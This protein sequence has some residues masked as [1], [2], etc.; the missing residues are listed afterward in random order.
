MSNEHSKKTVT[1]TTTNE[2]ATSAN[3]NA[4][5]QRKPSFNHVMVDDDIVDLRELVKFLRRVNGDFD[6]A[7]IHTE[8][9][10]DSM[11]GLDPNTIA[12]FSRFADSLDNITDPDHVRRL[13]ESVT[14]EPISVRINASI[15][16]EV[17]ICTAV[18][19][20]IWFYQYDDF[21][22]RGI[23][24]GSSLYLV[25]CLIETPSFIGYVR[26]IF[27]KYVSPNVETEGPK[28]NL[29]AV[30][31][32]VAASSAFMQVCD[33]KSYD[34]FKTVQSLVTRFNTVIKDHNESVFQFESFTTFITQ[35][36]L[37][38]QDLCGVDWFEGIV[39][40]YDDLEQVRQGLKEI[41]DSLAKPFDQI[42]VR[43]Q[44]CM[45]LKIKDKF[46]N[47]SIDKIKKSGP[48][49]N[50]ISRNMYE[51]EM[52]LRNRDAFSAVDRNEPFVVVMQGAPGIGKSTVMETVQSVLCRS[53]YPD[54][55]TYDRVMKNAGDYVWNPNQSESFDSGYKTQPI[56]VVEDVGYN[57][58][59]NKTILP[60]FIHWV[61]TLPV[62]TNQAAL[63]NKGNTYFTSE[64]ILCNTNLR[65]WS[66]VVS[67]LSQ[68]SALYRRLHYCASFIIKQE[69][70]DAEGKQ[71]L[72]KTMRYAQ[73]HGIEDGTCFWLDVQKFNPKDG[74]NNGEIMSMR[75]FME[76]IVQTM[77]KRR[78][79]GRVKRESKQSFIDAFK[80]K[81]MSIFDVKAEGIFDFLP[82]SF[83]PEDK[84]N[85]SS[86]TKCAGQVDFMEIF[87]ED[88][89]RD[90]C[91]CCNRGMLDLPA[92]YFEGK[93]CITEPVNVY[94]KYVLNVRPVN[95]QCA[96]EITA[97]LHRCW[98]NENKKKVDVVFNNEEHWFIAQLKEWGRDFVYTVKEVFSLTWTTFKTWF[99]FDPV[100][101]TAILG[102][103]IGAATAFSWWLKPKVVTKEQVQGVVSDRNA[104]DLAAKLMTS[105]IVRFTTD[106]KDLGMG[107]AIGGELILTN[108][109]TLDLIVRRVEKYPGARCQIRRAT[110]KGKA[111]VC[112]Y[113]M[114]SLFDS[115]NVFKYDGDLVCLRVPKFSSADLTEK[116][117]DIEW[118]DRFGRQVCLPYWE[119]SKDDDFVSKER[120]FGSAR[121]H[122]RVVATDPNTSKLYESMNTLKYDIPTK[123]GM[124]GC[125]IIVR[126]PRVSRKIVGIHC[127][128]TGGTSNGYG[129][130][131]TP[132]MIQDAIK[133]FEQVPVLV[134]ANNMILEKVD[135]D[136][137]PILPLEDCQ[138]VGKCKAKSVR[139]QSEIG[140]A[141]IYGLVEDAEPSMKPARLNPTWVGDELVNP[142]DLN[143]AQYARGWKEPIMPLFRGTEIAL[144][145]HYQSMKQP[146]LGRF[147]TN[148]EAVAGLPELP[149]FK[150]INRGTS[151]GFPDK[152]YLKDKKRSAF[153]Y[154]ENYTFDTEES[155]FIFKAVDD[156]YEH[157]KT[158]R[159]TTICSVFP[160]DEL[161]PSEKADALKT[162]L[163]MSA[164]L[165]MLIL[166]RRVFGPYMDWMIEPENRLYNFSAVG[167]N[168]ADNE[169][170]ND[171]V[172]LMGAGSEEFRVYAGDQSGFDK[173]LSPFLMDHQWNII[174][175]IFVNGGLWD[176]E[177]R[178]IAKNLYY[179][180]TRVHTQVRD[181]L[182]YWGN[183]NPSGWSLTTFTNGTSNALATYVACA[184]AVLGPKASQSEVSKFI[185]TVVDKKLIFVT[186]Y[187]D[188]VVLKVSRGIHFGYNFDLISNASLAEGY[189]SMGL[190]YTD[191]TKSTTFTEVDRTIFE[192]GFLK[193]TVRMVIRDDESFLVAYRELDSILQKVQWMRRTQTS[194]TLNKG[195]TYA[196]DEE[197]VIWEDKL[198]K[199]LNELAVHPDDVWE[200]WA[201]RL[202]EAYT[203]VSKD[204]PRRGVNLA[205][206]RDERI[207][208]WRGSDFSHT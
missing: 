141:P 163:I 18:A 94:E 114:K 179:S 24:L 79:V 85:V 169:E 123:S 164:P 128:G 178:I 91:K 73:E 202:I 182:I 74:S 135:L 124:C 158:K 57:T 160:K 71:D 100:K 34:I 134:E 181:N 127:A 54:D 139:F 104:E 143:M 200:K 44:G 1:S 144:L 137:Q 194:S 165:S 92:I 152:M 187:G 167:I 64:L 119:S 149:F 108:K 109:H 20:V 168:M 199:A 208:L 22:S 101:N 26:K 175:N 8:G 6:V 59:A 53:L 68:P 81:G 50:V 7:R 63:E 185:T 33:L 97:Y 39:P 62:S 197:L 176:E 125:P 45:F 99:L 49:Y 156:M 28:E 145:K 2:G 4:V 51:V 195:W 9:I 204:L 67:Q 10:F 82:C 78:M 171:Y 52:A 23:C 40:A 162:R 69:F 110:S 17:K 174:E 148:E 46:K 117:S 159:L 96:T 58:E 150:P 153:G 65:D 116:F 55:E 205:L 25:H 177:Q 131:V 190:V 105:S 189:L 66:S 48:V 95:T 196:S 188:D 183:S 42:N 75:Q 140:R 12:I 172:H 36:A 207:D 89:Y 166:T 86:C 106:E 138:V 198:E 186:T 77:A 132:T 154:D 16:M 15:P 29:W 122:G 126:D 35:I 203:K 133:H 38:I 157:L 60:K 130:I 180:C 155:K 191:E 103:I 87:K 201:P 27:M 115:K 30:A 161:R 206:T 146:K 5:R 120:L 41:S 76:D 61:G 107:T 113:D 93:P 90:V 121:L 37:T 70:A 31:T 173:K 83:P 11:F 193:R 84:C 98:M 118:N 13:V 170:L 56:V 32:G 129:I 184:H 102:A 111:Y 19:S 88:L 147:L 14:V 192:V 151:A 3:Q 142:I 136:S 80:T 21:V 112:D 72:E 43:A 47:M